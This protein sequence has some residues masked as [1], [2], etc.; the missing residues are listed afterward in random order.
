MRR[1]LLAL[2]VGVMMVSGCEK[3]DDFIV[4]RVGHYK[5]AEREISGLLNPEN[6]IDEWIASR[7]LALEAERRGLDRSEEIE[8]VMEKLRAKL[9]VNSLLSVEFAKL[10]TPSQK[11]IEDYYQSNVEEFRRMRDEVEF[12]SF[13]GLDEKILRDVAK[14]LRR[15]AKEE[16]LA[17][18]YPGLLYENVR[19]IDPGSMPRPFSLMASARRGTVIGPTEFGERQYVFKVV[20]IYQAGTVRHL[21][22]VRGVVIERIMEIQ[23][24][25][26]KERLLK[27]LREEYSPEVNI[28]RMK[29]AGMINGDIDE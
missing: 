9:L 11:E 19:I 15:G 17:D 4:A 8:T 12:I 25:L 27:K 7:L 22:D 2:I 10:D 20:E 23:K 3:N 18:L 6:Y 28:D 21:N 16:E 1:L 29:A 5:L 13:S 26:L 24:S 14:S